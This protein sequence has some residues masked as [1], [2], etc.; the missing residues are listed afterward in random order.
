MRCR[1]CGHEHFETLV[2]LGDTPLSNSYLDAAALTRPEPVHPLHAMVCTRCLLVQIDA[3]ESPEG[4]FGDY[5]YFS[6]YSDGWVAHAREYAQASIERLG[7]GADDLVVELASNDG[8]LLQHFLERGIPVLGIEPARNVAIV[9]RA[10]GIE[11]I[12]RFFGTELA[13]ELRE[14]GRAPRL[15]VANNVLAHVPDL[16]DFVGGIATLLPV[17]GVATLEFPHLLEL[18]AGVQFDTIYHEH[19]SYFSLH[20]LEPVLG[21]HDLLLTDVEQLTTHG[22]SLRVHVRQ[23]AANAEVS[24]A[25]RRIRALE[26]DAGLDRLSAYRGFAA[27]VEAVRRA[28]LDFL[29]A[30]R[31]SGRRVA[32]YGAPAKGNTLLNF[33][34]IDSD[35]VEFTVDR[36]PHKQGLFLPGS[37]IPIL[38]PEAVFERRPDVLLILPWNLAREISRQMREVREFGCEMFVPLPRV[39]PV[40]P[41]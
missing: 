18:L 10:A 27:E 34:G 15:V 40:P 22:G 30:A 16:N 1:G 41:A 8:Y 32:A 24:A 3:F 9:A 4:I 23:R 13:T 36:S 19:F 7:M 14:Q 20:A 29:R 38:A 28:L 26:H 31:D 21:A 2:D 33:C 37:H 5:A 6:S 35:L 25:V 11:T 17:N 12:G 39:T